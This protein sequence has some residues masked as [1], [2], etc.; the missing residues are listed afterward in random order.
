MSCWHNLEAATQSFNPALSHPEPLPGVTRQAI[1]DIVARTIWSA[2]DALER[3]VVLA[4]RTVGVA[5]ATQRVIKTIHGRAIALWR[6]SRI[7]PPLL[8]V[9]RCC[10]PYTGT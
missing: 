3:I 6:R 1:I 9:I 2:E 8:L 5:D 10:S 4:R 7:F